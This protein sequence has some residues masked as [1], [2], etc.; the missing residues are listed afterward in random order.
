M[1][2][3]ALQINEAK[4]LQDLTIRLKRLF[5]LIGRVERLISLDKHPSCPITQLANSYEEF[6]AL[7]AVSPLFIPQNGSLYTV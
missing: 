6:P 1:T 5:V 4:G 2:P 3:L 7:D